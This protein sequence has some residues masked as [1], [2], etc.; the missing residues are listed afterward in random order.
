MIIGIDI[1][2]TTIKGGILDKGKIVAQEHAKTTMDKKEF[3]FSVKNV[4]KYL[5]DQYPGMITGIGI[6]CPGPLDIEK[7]LIIN[8]PNLPHN[9][10]LG[11]LQQ[12]FGV[13]FFFHNDANCFALAEAVLGAGVGKRHV[14]GVTI[15]T[16][17]GCGLI[18]DEKIYAGRGN[19]AEIAHT[20]IR[21]DEEEKIQ[22]LV[23]GSVEQYI[24]T[25]GLLRLAAKYGLEAEDPFA[26]YQIAQ[27]KNE[28]ALAIFKEFGS[29]LGIVMT[30]CIHAYDPDIIVIGGAIAQAWP[31]FEEE[32][33]ASIEEHAMQN[34]PPIIR[35][36]LKD[37]NII[38]AALLAERKII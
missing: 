22:H 24:G 13:P 11:V 5:F 15:G 33:L 34:M 9:T 3:I 27:Y 36:Q 28:K 32:M 6:G 7:G 2:G 14:L 1:G 29:D 12:D 37:A 19:A 8:P 18:I 21:A 10:D 25:R 20:I 17:L 31:F 35:S 38:G 23:R 26:I 16:G 4:I 30:N